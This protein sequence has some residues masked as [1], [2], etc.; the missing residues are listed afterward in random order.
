MEKKAHTLFPFSEVGKGSSVVIYGAGDV[1]Q[2]FYWQI[3][4]SGYCRLAGWLDKQW[5]SSPKLFMPFICEDD[6]SHIQYDHLVIAITN[7]NVRAEI[8]T[9]LQG[10]GVGPEK[11][12]HAHDCPLQYTIRHP[13]DAGRDAPD[14]FL[15]LLAAE[16]GIKLNADAEPTLP[17]EQT[18]GG[19]SLRPPRRYNIGI[20]GAGRHAQTMALCIKRRFA[21]AC[22][23]G[24]VSRDMGKARNFAAAYDIPHVYGSCLEMAQEKAIDLVHICTPVEMHYEQTKLFLRHQ[25]H[26]LCEKPFARNKAE[27]ED[28]IS[29]ARREGLLLA[30]GM[31][32]RYM[33]MAQKLAEI[34]QSGVIGPISSMSASL[35]Y[36]GLRPAVFPE[37]G[38]YLVALAALVLGK[39]LR[40][41]SVSRAASD[42]ESYDV[43]TANLIWDNAVATL[44]CGDGASDRV[45]YIYGKKGFIAVEDA[46]EYRVI[47][48][49]ALASPS[50]EPARL[51]ARYDM[52]PGYEYEVRACLDAIASNKIETTLY[53][54]EDILFGMEALDEIRRQL[55]GI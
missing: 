3:I 19:P 52:S 36:P 13:S 41:L 42:T 54:H 18:K 8:T 33:P 23:Y 14:S 1:G 47:N 49:Y 37:V 46:N 29:L 50:S 45:A 7:D 30:E 43:F 44:S 10:I 17:R 5:A 38:C 31:W 34:I 12:V 32:P 48:V 21:D 26:V 55:I 51:V 6:L 28:M 24:V 20:V 53:R 27:A 4:S 35:F 22:L 16:C 9:K 40:G 39:D 15:R 2:A 11:I 25:K